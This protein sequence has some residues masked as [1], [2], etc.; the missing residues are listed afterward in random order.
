ME[1][2]LQVKLL[3]FLQDHK[4]FRIGDSKPILVDVRVICA[5]NKDL[6]KLIAEKRFRED[7][8]YRVNVIALLLPPLRER[9]EDIPALAQFF[10]NQFAERFGRGECRLSDEALTEL[11]AY[12]WPGNIRELQNVLERSVILADS[13]IDRHRAFPEGLQRA[14][15]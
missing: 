15:R 6:K 14:A 5:T 1:L 9:K 4:I 3:R 10:C 8:Y 13:P 12:E 7:L 2:P 11:M